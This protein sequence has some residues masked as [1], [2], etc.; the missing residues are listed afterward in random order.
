M[1]L[2]DKVNPF[3]GFVLLPLQIVELD[4][5][6]RDLSSKLLLNF[7]VPTHLNFVLF[8]QLLSLLQLRTQILYF[9]VGT[10]LE[11]IQASIFFYHRIVLLL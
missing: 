10:L 4:S 7:L 3:F 11:F 2:L 8:Q 6:L 9:D 5:L 1:D